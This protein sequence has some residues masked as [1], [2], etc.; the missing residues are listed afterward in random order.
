M[1]LFILW[2]PDCGPGLL[3]AARELEYEAVGWTVYVQEPGLLAKRPPTLPTW[4]PIRRP[5]VRRRLLDPADLATLDLVL[6]PPGT[7][8]PGTSSSGTSSSGTSSSG[9][10][11]SGTSSGPL[12]SPP[13]QLR[14][15]HAVLASPGEWT[16]VQA[17]L[18]KQKTKVWDLVS[19]C[20]SNE[21]TFTHLVNLPSNVIDIIQF[22]VYAA[23]FVPRRGLLALAAAK[24]IYFEICLDKALMSASMAADLFKNVLAVTRHLPRQNVL[25]SSGAANPLLM[26][27]PQ[28]LFAIAQILFDKHARNIVYQNP[29]RCLHTAAARKLPGA[30]ILLP[31]K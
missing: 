2:S 23:G 3:E 19:V 21:A 30:G 15:F 4:V 28:D 6:S 27:A 24:G 13:V 20:V 29:S 1:D 12:A 5:S 31:P 14:R 8:P 9:T 25:L 7:S 16:P 26:R 10:S 11:S 18:K 17:Y 22:D